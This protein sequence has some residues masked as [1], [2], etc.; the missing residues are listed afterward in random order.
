MNDKPIEVKCSVGT[1]TSHET[2]LHYN[3]QCV[4]ISMMH[5]SDLCVYKFV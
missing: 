4:F 1:M 3:D 5:N 2:L